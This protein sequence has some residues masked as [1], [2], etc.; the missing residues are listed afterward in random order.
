MPH[1][2]I[3]H[4]FNVAVN[5]PRSLILYLM[6]LLDNPGL[7]YSSVLIDS[8][9]LAFVSQVLFSD[10]ANSFICF[11]CCIDA[12]YLQLFPQDPFSTLLVLKKGI[13]GVGIICIRIKHAVVF[14]VHK[15]R[16][17]KWL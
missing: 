3:V 8:S 13:T 9:A 10:V 1:A 16:T 15:F 11:Y 5:E 17:M 4:N 7:F 2:V 12:C 6:Y 14:S